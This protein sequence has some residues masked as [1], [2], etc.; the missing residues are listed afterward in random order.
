VNSIWS[1]RIVLVRPSAPCNSDH[2]ILGISIKV[3]I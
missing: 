1:I 3:I 2:F